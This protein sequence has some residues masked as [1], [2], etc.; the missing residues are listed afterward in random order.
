MET[1]KPSDLELQVL[2]VLWK[3][4]SATVREV[5]EAI[6]D[7]KTRAYTTILSTMQVME[8]KGLIQRAGAK[9]LTHI[10]QAG[11]TRRQV[12]G[13]LFQNLIRNVFGG[14]SS[15]A[16]Q[17]LLRET[18]ICDEDLAEIDKLIHGHRSE[19]QGKDEKE[20]QP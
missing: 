14:S 8:K 2:S 13:P 7:G 20:I 1:N 15:A 10:F 3:K 16:V 6:P 19:R 11:V 4:G 9:G 17:H 5:L 12:L 18:D